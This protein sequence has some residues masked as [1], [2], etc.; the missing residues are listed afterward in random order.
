VSGRLPNGFM[1]AYLGIAVF[2]YH[3]FLF[4]PRHEAVGTEEINARP[5]PVHV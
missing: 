5:I 1:L 3:G 2:L 4:F